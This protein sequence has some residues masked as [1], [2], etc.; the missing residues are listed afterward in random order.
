MATQKNQES[1][2]KDQK[3]FKEKSL[4]KEKLDKEKNKAKIDENIFA[5]DSPKIKST[6]ASN[7][8]IKSSIESDKIND[9]ISGF[10]EKIITSDSPKMNSNL[11]SNAGLGSDNT[12]SSDSI[13]RK[14]SYYEYSENVSLIKKFLKWV[15]TIFMSFL[16]SVFKLFHL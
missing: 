13:Y 9:L 6:L 3:I 7:A 5:S 12:K 2:K 15:K 10:N 1:N 4:K 16:D 8:T 11:A 14:E